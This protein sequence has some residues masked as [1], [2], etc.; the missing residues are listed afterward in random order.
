MALVVTCFVLVLAFRPAQKIFSRYGDQNQQVVEFD[1]QK[2]TH[3]LLI[4]AFMDIFP[5]GAGDF[6]QDQSLEKFLDFPRSL[7]NGVRI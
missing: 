4:A 1:L 7:L 3:R 5:R 6:S 2:K